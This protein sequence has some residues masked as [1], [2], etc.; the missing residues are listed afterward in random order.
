MKEN[1]IK[2]NNIKEI[3][4]KVIE[5]SIADFEHWYFDDFES[6]IGIE[7]EEDLTSGEFTKNDIEDAKNDWIYFHEDGFIAEVCNMLNIECETG[8]NNK[9]DKIL[10]EIVEIVRESLRVKLNV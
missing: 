1:N 7:K 5:H 4:N 3:T 10:E 9:H 2:E 6:D 8:I